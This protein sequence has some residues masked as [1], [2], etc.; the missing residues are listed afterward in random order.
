MMRDAAVDGDMVRAIPGLR[1]F[2]VSLCRNRDRADELVQETLTRAISR[3]ST[4][5]KGTNLD[6]WLFTIL[7]N[8]FFNDCRRSKRAVDGIDR[9]YAESR[10]VPLDQDGWDI[11]EDLRDGLDKLSSTHRQALFLVGASGL[12]Y[13][14]A[15]E[16]AGCEVG[17]MKSR[18]FRARRMLAAHMFGEAGKGEHHNSASG[19]AP[20]RDHFAIPR[21]TSAALMPS[22]AN[23]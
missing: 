11:A 8:N 1:A 7:R 6:A 10:T 3:I 14:E 20:R 2:A 15:A 17:T 21:A 16:I 9:Q 13:D 23:P 22:S 19:F 4:F 5:E 18:V 12:S